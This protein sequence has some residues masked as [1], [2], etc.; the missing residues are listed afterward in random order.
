MKHLS[1]NSAFA[2]VF[3]TALFATHL[4][5][6]NSQGTVTLSG[7]VSDQSG[8]SIAFATVMLIDGQRAAKETVSK[9]DGTYQL[10]GLPPGQYRILVTAKGF[11]S[12]ESSLFDL[13]PTRSKVLNLTLSVESLKEEIEVNSES[14]GALNTVR[15]ANAD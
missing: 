5:S 1:A 9:E 10:I 14:V 8:G 13:G 11:A 6:A 3:L 4:V 12:K 15:D 2:L 7:R